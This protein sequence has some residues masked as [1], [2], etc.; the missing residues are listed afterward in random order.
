MAD[1]DTTAYRCRQCDHWND[2]KRCKGWKEPK[3]RGVPGTL[4]EGSRNDA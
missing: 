3:A 4:T 1:F 2:L